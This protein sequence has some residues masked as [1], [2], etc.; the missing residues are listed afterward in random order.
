M[1]YCAAFHVSH[2]IVCYGCYIHTHRNDKRRMS[3]CTRVY[4]EIARIL[5]CIV[6]QQA[7]VCVIKKAITTVQFRV[8]QPE[9]R[10]ISNANS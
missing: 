4:D 6:Y 3:T 8:Q 10:V 5:A 2:A 7:V 9:E 1:L